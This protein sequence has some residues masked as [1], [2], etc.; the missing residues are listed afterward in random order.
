M[1]Q[2]DLHTLELFLDWMKRKIRLQVLTR[3]I[4]FYER[5]IWW[6]SLGENIGSEE[7]GKHAQFERPVIVLKRVSADLLFVIP[8]STVIKSG[9]WYVTFDFHGGQRSALLVQTRS[10][11]SQR[12]IRKMGT[13][14]RKVFL[15][16]QKTFISY[17]QNG[18]LG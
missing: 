16:I 1:D 17:I 14:E 4:Y 18:T 8:I 12:L 13:I 11:S 2:I 9:S 10:I 15:V 3:V 6:A 5:E 7:N